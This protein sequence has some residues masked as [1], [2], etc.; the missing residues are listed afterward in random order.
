MDPISMKYGEEPNLHFTLIITT[1]LIGN[2]SSLSHYRSILTS[3]NG[4]TGYQ[5]K[6]LRTPGGINLKC[7]TILLRLNKV[8]FR[9]SLL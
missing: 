8:Y 3:H 1:S 5:T 6:G 4:V 9:I 7:D 2:G